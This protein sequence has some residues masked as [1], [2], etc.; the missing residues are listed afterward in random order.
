MGVLLK[1]NRFKKER[2][3]F[4]PFLKNFKREKGE[5]GGGAFLISTKGGAKP[6]KK[7]GKGEKKRVFFLKGGK[8]FFFTKRGKKGGKFLCGAHC[9]GGHKNR[10]VWG[11][12]RGGKTLFFCNPPKK[13]VSPFIKLFFVGWG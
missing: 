7:G 9:W 11:G 10:G 2:K 6:Q 12:P 13:K 1:K 8:Y 3:K 5:K 4:F